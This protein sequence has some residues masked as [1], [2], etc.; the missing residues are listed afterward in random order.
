MNNQELQNQIEVLTKQVEE[1]K[2]TSIQ[3]QMD[4]TT[5]L[6]LGAAFNTAINNVLATKPTQ[7]YSTSTPS[8][9]APTGSLWMYNSGSLATNEIHVYSGSA[10]IRMK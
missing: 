9:T 8:G 5:V 10:W 2:R 7:T 1:L 4:P 3:V 6:Y